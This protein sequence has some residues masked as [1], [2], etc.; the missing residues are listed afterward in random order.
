LRPKE[1]YN[2]CCAEASISSAS[3]SSSWTISFPRAVTALNSL[4]TSPWALLAD[5]LV[6]C[7]H[8]SDTAPVTP[9]DNCLA[10]TLLSSIRRASSEFPVGLLRGKEEEE[11]EEEEE[12]VRE[13]IIIT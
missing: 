3:S 10:N 2:T 4:C 5:S 9:W 6:D 13:W 8:R 1:P 11:E 12:V 7:C